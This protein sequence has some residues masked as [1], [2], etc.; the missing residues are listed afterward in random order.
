MP[1]YLWSE[2]GSDWVPPDSCIRGYRVL[3]ILRFPISEV[4]YL[5]PCRRKLRKLANTC[6][7]LPRSQIRLSKTSMFV[8]FHAQW[9]K[10]NKMEQTSAL[11]RV[12]AK[13]LGLPFGSAVG[14]ALLAELG[15][16]LLAELG[17]AP[18]QCGRAVPDRPAAY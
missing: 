13:A 10:W 7:L 15:L 8:P 5:A 14:L 11:L 1:P 18:R 3:T 12:L 16:A 9:N 4:Q 17:L 6:I 2:S